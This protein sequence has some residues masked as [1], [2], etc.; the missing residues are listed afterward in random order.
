MTRRRNGALVLAAIAVGIPIVALAIDSSPE[1]NDFVV[2]LVTMPL[3]ALVWIAAACVS[4]ARAAGAF[5]ARAWRRA[6]AYGAFPALTLVVVTHATP[7][8]RAFH[9]AGRV[10][11]FA[12]GRPWYDRRVA[13]AGGRLT[14]F[15]WGGFVGSSDDLVYDA[16]GDIMLP[17]SR[18]PARWSAEI[19]RTD[20]ACPV[21]YGVTPLWDHYYA[22]HDWC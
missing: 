16:S 19:A 14:V 2:W 21:G 17:A 3:F 12:I 15:A 8:L 13:A 1:A 7:T 4:G 5:R 20:L 9:D 6:L 11:R 22:V 18:R 10:I